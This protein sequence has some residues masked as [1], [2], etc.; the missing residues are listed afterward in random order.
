[1]RN[2]KWL[3]GFLLVVLMMGLVSLLVACG[4][5]EE[6][7]T[8]AQATATTAAEETTTTVA[9]VE[10]TG[11][12]FDLKFT[13]GIPSMANLYTAYLAPWAE[14]VAEATDGRV[15][16]TIYADNTLVKGT[17]HWDAILDGTADMGLVEPEQTA[18]AFPRSEIY[19]LPFLFPDSETTAGVMWDYL[20]EYCLD[21]WEGVKILGVGVILPAEF[22][23]MKP[24]KVPADLEGYRMRSGA[25]VETWID[26]ALG[27]TPVEIETSDLAVSFER[28]LA[29]GS[30]I[31]YDLCMAIGIADVA[32]NITELKILYRAWPIIINQD[33]WDS[34]PA[35]L[36]DQI[37][38]VSG[39]DASMAYD[40]AIEAQTQ[41]LKGA[42]GGK[43]AAGG[44][45][46]IYE[47]TEEEHALWVDAVMPVYDKWVEELGSDQPGQELLDWIQDKIAEYAAQ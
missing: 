36:Q 12:T 6:A 20:H 22:V 41:G 35:T 18:G 21:E 39:K 10:D 3:L 40:A 24:A 38:S 11:Q 43:L 9:G 46:P 1:M 31:T 19:L 47:P 25:R 44:N 2:K 34:I 8:T 5:E 17:Q 14:D 30:L 28:G 27:A 32:T 45:D 16:I 33:V 15:N 29:D 37:M 23:G 13:C 26:E 7:T 4:E 42:V